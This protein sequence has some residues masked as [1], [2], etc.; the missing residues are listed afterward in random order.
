MALTK[1]KL[2][3]TQLVASGTSTAMDISA[4]YTDPA[5]FRFYNGTSGTPTAAAT[6]QLQGR[7][8]GGTN[9]HNIGPLLSGDLVASSIL[10]GVVP[11]PDGFGSLQWVYTAPSGG[12]VTGFTF[13]SDVPTITGI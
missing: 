9:Y 11:V 7:A 8:V 4:V 6:A 1:S 5:C 2:S 3:I 10:T 13:D 12:S